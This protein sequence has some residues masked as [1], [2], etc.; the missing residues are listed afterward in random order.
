MPMEESDKKD[1]HRFVQFVLERFKNDTD[2]SD[3]ESL[4]M[5]LHHFFQRQHEGITMDF[6]VNQLL[7]YNGFTIAVPH[8]GENASLKTLAWIQR[9]FFEDIYGLLVFSFG[10][11]V[12]GKMDLK[13]ED[14]TRTENAFYYDQ[15]KIFKDHRCS[16]RLSGRKI[17]L[18]N[19]EFFMTS[20]LLVLK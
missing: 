6:T 5:V 16:V 12:N 1:F 8:F 7:C 3:F 20:F 14:I 10:A 15:E 18:M 13:P 17:E 19:R 11:D 4:V 2:R 9:K